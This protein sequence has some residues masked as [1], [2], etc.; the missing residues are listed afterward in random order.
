M[1]KRIVFSSINSALC[2][3]LMIW[4]AFSHHPCVHVICVLC[5]SI[6]LF[7]VCAIFAK[8][9]HRKCIFMAIR[10]SATALLLFSA[11]QTPW[12]FFFN[13][14]STKPFTLLLVLFVPI[15][16]YLFSLLLIN[17]IQKTC[18]GLICWISLSSLFT[19]IPLYA[20]VFAFSTYLVSAS[21]NINGT[22]N[23]NS[24]GLWVWCILSP[25]VYV[26]ALI[27]IRLYPLNKDNMPKIRNPLLKPILQK[28]LEKE[29]KYVLAI[30]FFLIPYSIFSIIVAIHFKF[31]E[32]F[33][34]FHALFVALL[35]IGLTIYSLAK[36]DNLEAILNG[37][38]DK[39]KE[40]K[41]ETENK[42]TDKGY[43]IYLP[44]FK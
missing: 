36:K 17:N 19:L 5:L 9:K 40:N 34:L 35:S 26:F 37:K 24:F 25:L 7:S 8:Q 11:L 32:W 33:T 18:R 42:K 21:I 3:G 16:I 44:N 4:L 28:K 15:L 2:L 20:V 1:K 14:H 31:F 39:N 6:F 23:F 43:E 29:K 30:L 10:I 12:L 38:I 41:P 27:L 22:L 13:V